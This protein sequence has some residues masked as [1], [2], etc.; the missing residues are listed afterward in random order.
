AVPLT[1]IPRYVALWRAGKLPVERIVS[2]TIGLDGLND[3]MD[4]LANGEAL[5]TIVRPNAR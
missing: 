5:R 2:G 3:A 1:D 4:A